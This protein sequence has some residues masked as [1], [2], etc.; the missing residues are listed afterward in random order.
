MAKIQIQDVQAGMVLNG[1]VTDEAG[2][3]LLKAGVSLSKHHL[4][5]LHAHGVSSIQVDNGG[6]ETAAPAK[7]GH[8]DTEQLFRNLDPD[9]PLV[10]ELKRLHQQRQPNSNGGD[11][12]ED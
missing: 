12:D 5:L 10:R 2:H 3:V 8:A 1:D 11:G 6:G 4:A 9:H 7:A